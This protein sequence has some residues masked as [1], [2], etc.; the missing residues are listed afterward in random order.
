M[1]ASDHIICPMLPL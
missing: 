1:D